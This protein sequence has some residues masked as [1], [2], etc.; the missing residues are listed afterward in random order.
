MPRLPTGRLFTTCF[1]CLLPCVIDSSPSDSVLVWRHFSTI[2]PCLCHVASSLFLLMSGTF[3]FYLFP[4]SSFPQACSNPLFSFSQHC[5]S[6]I[7]PALPI[8]S[9]QAF[10]A[11]SLPFA[12]L[13][14]GT[15]SYL[16]IMS[17]FP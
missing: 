12:L 15:V 17:A 4:S 11:S 13:N 1:Q 8:Y 5:A 10:L 3:V 2:S 9:K 14:L 7:S 16:I 6:T